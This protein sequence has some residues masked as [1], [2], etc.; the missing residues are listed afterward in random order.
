[1][2]PYAVELIVACHYVY[3][4]A[5]FDADLEPFEIYLSE[6]AFRHAAVAC[7]ASDFLIVAREVLGASSFAFALYSFS[8]S[9]GEFAADKRVFRVIF[10]VSSAQ[11]I[12]VYV[13]AR[14]E[15][16]V[17]VVMYHFF[18]DFF[19]QLFYEFGIP[20]A[21]ECGAAREQS[22][23]MTYSYTG[24]SVRSDYRAHAFLFE[25]FYYT[26]VCARVA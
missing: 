4:I 17:R 6:C 13:H 20:S 24:R 18:A 11:R 8:E 14:A 2:T 15:K 5:F 3:R 7:V 9:R 26:A 12:A 22:V 16:Y 21:G 25:R 19:I 1:V 10:E 23:V